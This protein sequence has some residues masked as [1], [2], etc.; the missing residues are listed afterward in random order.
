MAARIAAPTRHK[1]AA[2]EFIELQT[3]LIFRGFV[4]AAP[5]ID[6]QST[7]KYENSPPGITVSINRD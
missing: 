2:Q 5:G 4:G 1:P 7:A 6:A 3:T